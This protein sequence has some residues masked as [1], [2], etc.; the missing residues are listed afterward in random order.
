MSAQQRAARQ[1]HSGVVAG[2]P[3]AISRAFGPAVVGFFRPQIVIPQRITDWPVQEQALVLA[4]EREHIAAKDHVAIHAA[5]IAVACVPWN[6][7][8]W[9]AARQLRHA[10]EVDCDARVLRGTPNVSAYA[11]LVLNVATWRQEMPANSLALGTRALQQLERR[12]VQMTDDSRQRRPATAFGLFVV[13]GLLTTYACASVTGVAKPEPKIHVLEPIVT[14]AVSSAKPFTEFQVDNPAAVVFPSATPRY[15]DSLRMAGVEGEVTA[16][17]VVNESGLADFST[18]KI[19]NSP[20]EL[21]VQS[22][23][24]TI[25]LMRFSPAEV[26][27]VK[28]RQLVQ[29]IFE[30]TIAR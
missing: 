22:V 29:Q 3:V 12:I 10:I 7:F 6:P 13:A 8:L 24:A 18:L 4:H 2:V 16:Q 21:F 17:F 1:W 20:N 27:G 30:F 5:A 19:L 23:Q 14:T 9:F 11:E 26:K 25:P 15:P 28:V